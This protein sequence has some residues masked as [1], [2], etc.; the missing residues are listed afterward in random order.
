[1]KQPAISLCMIVKNE[2]VALPR[3]LRSVAGVADEIVVVDTGSTD[4]TVQIAKNFGAKVVTAAWNGDFSAARNAGLDRARGTWIL[5]LDADEELD[6]GDKEQLR[7]CTNHT[8]YEAFFLQVHN[9]SGETAESFAA[10][11]NPI[12]RMFRNRP[13]YRFRGRIHEQIAASIM[14]QRP[15]AH[16]HMTTVKIHHYG[17]SGSV[18]TGKNKIRRNV[19]LLEK[20]LSEHPGDPFTHYNV[21]VEHMRMANWSSALAHLRESMSLAGP[22]TS[23]RHLLHKYESR[24]LLEMARYEDALEAL[25]R[26]IARFPDYTDLYHMKGAVLN[27]AER[28]PE[29]KEQFLLALSKGRPPVHYNTDAG[30][31]TYLSAF[32]LAQICEELGE[33]NAAIHWYG[34]AFRHN[35][36]WAAPLLKLIRICKVARQ[37]DRLAVLLKERFLPDSE[38]A[39]VKVVRALTEENCHTAAAALLEVYPGAGRA[40]AADE[41]SE[42]EQAYRQIRTLLGLADT[43]LSY[44][45]RELPYSDVYRRVRRRLPFP[46]LDR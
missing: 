1:M 4:E 12:V 34:E 38:A 40:A 41:T 19:E 22:D 15:Q 46:M 30:T 5:F 6:A 2:A 20:E 14:E 27:A 28:K 44:L 16:F 35:P 3:C 9:H 43:H 39:A 17:Y 10:T 8:E 32:A 36:N 45:D 33:D 31:G 26:G 21:A 24:C 7:I 29:A 23:Y 25:D 13:S 18:M 37:E 42:E 11:V